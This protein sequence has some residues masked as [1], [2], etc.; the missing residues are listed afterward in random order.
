MIQSMTGFGRSQLSVDGLS[1]NIELS[2]V[3]R[4]NLELSVNLPRDWQGLERELQAA[5]RSRLE[6]GK[7]HLLLNAAPEAAAGGFQWDMDG[8]TSSCERLK[9]AGAQHGLEW[10]PDWEAFVKIAALNKVE[11]SLPDWETIRPLLLK[12]LDAALDQL[13]E[14]RGKEGT[15]LEADLLERVQCVEAHLDAIRGLT[16]GNS[17]RYGELLQ[18][19]LRTAGLEVEL[20]DERV[21]KEISLFADRCDTSE[22]LTRLES[23]FEQFKEALAAGSPIGRKLEFIIQEINRELNT[24]GS[25]ANH[26]EVSRHVI[27]AKNEVERM[28]EQ[29]MNIE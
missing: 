10:P 23:H 18:Q 25:K 1:L 29:V 9:E 16:E 5:M 24:T 7:V 21:L 2:S 6:R 13:V 19:R 15:A 27:D 17:A 14:M 28:R 8:F 4:R 22:E 12:C 26:T 20:S 11:L 3:N